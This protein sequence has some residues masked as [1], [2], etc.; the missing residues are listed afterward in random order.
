VLSIARTRRTI[1]RLF[2][3]TSSALAL[4][5]AC[6]AETPPGPPGDDWAHRYEP[7]ERI[8]FDNVVYYGTEELTQL[9]LPEPPKSGFRV[10]ANPVRLEPYEERYFCQSW[11]I[12]E[13]THRM[14]Y[15]AEL[16]TTTG[17]HHGNMFVLPED[18]RGPQPSP[19]CYGGSHEQI[20]RVLVDF[21]AGVPPTEI[22]IPDV[23][24]ANSTQVVGTEQLPFPDGSAVRIRGNELILDTHLFNPTPD[25]IV[26][27]VAY[28]F[29]TMPEADVDQVLAS[30]TFMWLDFMI[31]AREDKDLVAD[32]DWAG[33][34]VAT[35][36]PHM[37]EWATGFDVKFFD[38]AGAMV[39]NPYN[40]TGFT[41]PDGD[42]EH[43]DP[44][45]T[46]SEAASRVQFTCTYTNTTDHAMCNG[47]GENEMCFLFGYTREEDQVIGLIP[48]EGAPCISM[49]I[50]RP[51]TIPPFDLAAYIASLD[52]AVRDRLLGLFGGS[53]IGG[54][55]MGNF[56]T[57]PE[58]S[59]PGARQ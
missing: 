52:P 55:G 32:C 53:A 28:D 38:D 16:H 49:N 29:Y 30:F 18:P 23:L 40:R 54:D 47:T 8:D 6:T 56:S 57:C 1:V 17:L 4:L 22:E 58:L 24:F 13:L 3:S 21:L 19:D 27:E 26:V 43:Y 44:I 25:P 59:P 42:I 7:L 15:T 39:S 10:V 50:G 34:S 9:E 51:E 46:E 12:P 36:M 48:T 14:V 41:N 5:C 33:G 35:I 37:H 45:H 11:Q 2:A 31:D 20:G